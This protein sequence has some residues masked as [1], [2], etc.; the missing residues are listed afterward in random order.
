MY[1]PKSSQVK[2]QQIAP[3]FDCC[4]SFSAFRREQNKTR[5]PAPSPPNRGRLH[6]QQQLASPCGSSSPVQEGG[7]ELLRPSCLA[8]YPLGSSRALEKMGEVCSALTTCSRPL[9]FCIPLCIDTGSILASLLLTSLCLGSAECFR[10]R[11]SLCSWA[12]SVL[13]ARPRPGLRFQQGLCRAACA[14]L[15]DGSGSVT[16]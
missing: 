5:N 9:M 2:K 1:C 4:F 6:L 16:T 15:L 14:S 8:E 3:H 13:A 12:I 10:T 7:M 11:P